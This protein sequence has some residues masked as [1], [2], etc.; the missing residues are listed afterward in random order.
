MAAASLSGACWPD[1]DPKLVIQQPQQQQQQQ[2]T[3]GPILV[4]DVTRMNATP[5]DRIFFPR[6][7]EDVAAILALARRHKRRVC[8]RGTKHSMGG[9]TVAPQAFLIDMARL[10]QVS[11]DPE[12]QIVACGPGTRWCELIK[13]LNQFGLS[14]RTMQSYSN[15]S[16]GGSISVNAHG[17]TTDFC[18]SESVVSLDVLTWDGRFM[19]CS[20]TAT[21]AETG[22]P[23]DEARELFKLV[24]GGYG[25]F[26]I[27]TEVRLKVN[28]NVHLDMDR[29][30]M[31]N[32][33][34]FA[35]IY[36]HSLGGDGGQGGQGHEDG[37]E[38]KLAR[39]NIYAPEKVDLFIFRR[40]NLAGARTIS[41]LPDHPR[42]M[43]MFQKILYKWL[44]P[45][46]GRVRPSIEALMGRAIDMKDDG[47]QR[48]ELMFETA[49]PL[50]K[51]YS[52]LFQVDDTFVLQEYFVPA[53]KYVAFIHA[54][55]P[56][57]KLVT[58]DGRDAIL[59]NTTVRYVHED[60]DAFLPYSSSPGGS[61]AFVLYYRLHR[62]EAGDA[63]L[64][65]AHEAFTNIT[66]DL[67]GTF[68][69]PYRH[70]YSAGDL[71]KAYPMI[72]VFFDKK[73]H[74][75][76]TGMF[77]NRWFLAYGPPK[78]QGGSETAAEEW[79]KGS[80]EATLALPPKPPAVEFA[81]PKTADRRAA[82]YRA[83]LR[84]PSLRSLF[85]HGFLERIFNAYPDND[86]LMGL[87][88]RAAWDPQNQTDF[89]IYED[90]QSLVAAGG[91]GGGGL[92]EAR[93]AWKKLL[94]LR[95][96]K[97]EL[98]RETGA[99]LHRLGRLG[100][101]RDYVSI[102]DQGKMVLPFKEALGVNGRIW[103]VNDTESDEIP[104]ILERGSLEP[105]GEFVHASLY[106]EAAFPEKLD[107]S[108]ESA[109]LVTMNQGLHHLP[110]AC[111]MQ[112][113]SEIRRI[114]RP[115]GLFIVREHD[116][117][118]DLMPMLD[119]AHSVFNAV[120]GVS[121]RDERSEL[122]A[123]RPVVEWRRII[124]AAGFVDT[125]LYEV[126]EGDPT[127]DEML[128][129]CACSSQDEVVPLERTIADPLP[130]AKLPDGKPVL[131]EWRSWVDQSREAAS[132]AASAEQ[133]SA[134]SDGSGASSV[135]S[136]LEKAPA[137]LLETLTSVTESLLDTLPKLKETLL[138]YVDTLPAG[139]RFMG[140]SAI[141]GLI[142][143]AID[144]IKTFRPALDNVEVKKT[145]GYPALVSLIPPEL[146]LLVRALF[147]RVEKGTASANE[148]VAVAVIKEIIG[149]FVASDDDDDDD[150]DDEG[151]DEGKD[152][153]KDD[154]AS[155]ATAASSATTAESIDLSEGDIRSCIRDLVQAH[156]ELLEKGCLERAGFSARAAAAL[157]SRLFGSSQSDRLTVPQLVRFLK[158]Y[159]DPPAWIAMRGHLVAIA[160]DPERHR[161]SLQALT[162]EGSSWWN[163]AMVFFAS[164]QVKLKK[165]ALMMARWVG[166][167]PIVDMYVVAKDVRERSARNDAS[168]AAEGKGAEEG[169]RG[170]GSLTSSQAKQLESLVHELTP[171]VE[172]SMEETS[173]RNI[174]DV[175]QI[176]EAVVTSSGSSADVTVALGER[177]DAG[178][179]LRL[180][181]LSLDSVDGV[182]AA[183]NAGYRFGDL[184]RTV[185]G[186]G[187]KRKGR[188]LTVRF[189]RRTTA[190]TQGAAFFG[191][192]NRR[193]D[194]V[195]ATMARNGIP[196]NTQTEDSKAEWN[197]YKLR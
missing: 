170:K 190:A 39:L 127:K 118:P 157:E 7:R 6:A 37:V 1:A 41:R 169:L 184:T 78:A 107:I 122:R 95:A 11:F 180:E 60:T 116:A 159:L 84:D 55:K 70:H 35:R 115:G 164:D 32:P 66:L 79:A 132:A 30:V 21:V 168:S 194:S 176:V 137:A 113:L 85:R 42:E 10:N 131:V 14:P 80:E 19:Q 143:P 165:T 98:T 104:S 126:E 81:V 191:E 183:P 54:A 120:N 56:V 71:R 46:L 130:Q 134:N 99:I 124:E 142:T 87:M 45:A 149:F 121:C 197:W 47:A 34:D 166:L 145:N 67:G 9:Q 141:E 61:F 68:Y 112:F 94:Q 36:R 58:A 86:L 188:V 23:D 13:H 108:T 117:T 65:E 129:F 20:R 136:M 15:F 175:E 189:T 196:V 92:G 160:A 146:S 89:E 75:D 53:E 181:G 25:L 133:P 161:F 172:A 38:V 33:E 179:T 139:Q 93:M 57:F 106:S 119:L 90:L 40:A 43:G 24:I 101:I 88:K 178:G 50:G 51:L 4:D 158:A 77:S 44:M 171:P 12:A 52:P 28:N 153:R 76:P 174:T 195:L 59:L 3:P 72:D 96:Q 64:R 62:T 109:D 144:V 110:Q 148:V 8:V 22:E 147:A 29:I 138:T 150:D 82:S 167:A 69:L 163:V 103:I 123:F 102:G 154:A 63:Q 135:L 187:R 177:L 128:C 17:I 125:M 192:L 100:K 49:E 111:L 31:S 114:L 151:K 18:C 2:Q 156:P 152:E 105:V 182:P 27:I 173:F 48:N 186:H 162:A 91:G 26:G 155:L 74:W 97:N 73:E 185:I 83:L 193:I 16:V 5:V 140:R